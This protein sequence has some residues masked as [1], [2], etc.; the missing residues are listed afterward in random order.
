MISVKSSNGN[1]KKE[2]GYRSLEFQEEITA[3]GINLGLVGIHMVSEPWDWIK[4]CRKTREKITKFRGLMV[5]KEL[6]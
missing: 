3:G 4:S 6:S 2:V 5:E 1:I